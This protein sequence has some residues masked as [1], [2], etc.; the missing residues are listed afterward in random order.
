MS[1]AVDRLLD[2]LGVQRHVALLADDWL[3]LPWLIRSTE[4]IAILPRRIAAWAAQRGDF[5][6]RELPGPDRAPF[7]E[8]AFYHPSRAADPGLCWIVDALI[9]AMNGDRPA[10]AAEA[11]AGVIDPDDI[12]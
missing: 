6:L 11:P 1:T 8:A 7:S 4:M 3:P 12:G 5:A 9:A 10:L 2:A